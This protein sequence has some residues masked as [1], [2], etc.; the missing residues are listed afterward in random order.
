MVTAY[1]TNNIECGNGGVS[2]NQLY[3]HDPQ[4]S[5]YLVSFPIDERINKLKSLIELGLACIQKTATLQD[6]DFANR[7]FDD[8][9]ASIQVSISNIPDL[10][11]GKLLSEIGTEKGQALEPIDRKV[12]ELSA[13]MK[14][15][16]DDLKKFLSEDIDP[17]KE[18]SKVSQL[19]T[20]LDK[21]LDSQYETSIPKVVE[22][23]IDDIVCE[24]GV[25]AHNVKA[26]VLDAMKP[27]QEEVNRLGREINSKQAVVD[28]LDQTVEKGITYEEDT[29]NKLRSFCGNN[30]LEV[31]HIGADNRSGDILIYGVGHNIL[32]SPIGIVVETKAKTN[33]SGRKRIND[34]MAS[35]MSERSVNYGIYLSR[36]A[37][38]LANEI[39][40]WAEGENIKGSWI[41][42]TD[43]YILVAIRVLL[44][45]HSLAMASSGSANVDLSSVEPQII[46]IKTS[47]KAI[48]NIKRKSSVLRETADDIQAE[49]EGL[50]DDIRG[51]LL[52]IEDAL[53]I[54]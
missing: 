22:S 45:K 43:E 47:L 39:G 17:S 24:N 27:L 54:A 37:D 11:K 38:G 6:R 52:N 20:K 18:G 15:R 31:H 10:L 33:A 4:L 28:A 32:N 36:D 53:R 35:A 1:G 23:M 5:G 3:L 48:S 49:C 19:F 46:R 34:A 41:A 26:V 40:D 21:Q 30:G 44:A 16:T 29:V 50:R 2:V 25:V 12:N 51:A 42:T 7:S 9:L 13:V 14:E 8:L